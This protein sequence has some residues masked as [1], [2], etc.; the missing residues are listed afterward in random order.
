M[1]S[2]ILAFFS[3]LLG[4]QQEIIRAASQTQESPSRGAQ[5]ASLLATALVSGGL[6]LVVVLLTSPLWAGRV[7]GQHAGAVVWA[8]AA[9]IT[10]YLVTLTINGVLI[11]Q[12]QWDKVAAI[13]VADGAVRFICVVTATSLGARVIG[14]AWAIAAA[15]LTW[16]FF[17]P[18]RPVREALV[19]RGDA[20]LRRQ[21]FQ[22]CLLV[23]GAV[24]G[25]LLVVGFPALL[26]VTSSGA[27]DDEA[28]VLLAVVTFTR[29][30]IVLPLI[31]FQGIAITYFVANRDA[32]S[33]TDRARADRDCGTGRGGWSG[34]RPHRSAHAPPGAG[35]PI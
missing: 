33:E 1:W 5:G 3:A 23:G 13:I 26:Q 30:P 20:S 25:T 31:A 7:F 22:A 34:R 27:L 16:L 19:T 6:L 32:C 28:G 18:W 2:L 8:S 15:G 14:W 9:G 12:R 35:R 10:C 24:C 17:L 29:A 21:V 11:G 4:V